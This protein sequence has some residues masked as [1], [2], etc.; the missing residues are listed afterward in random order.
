[1]SN[2]IILMLLGKLWFWTFFFFQKIYK[3]INS[4]SEIK[5]F[6]YFDEAMIKCYHYYQYIIHIE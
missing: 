6:I 2:S 4:N 3:E 5:I 1:M